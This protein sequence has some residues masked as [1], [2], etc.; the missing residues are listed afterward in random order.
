MKKYR[1]YGEY[2]SDGCFH[3]RTDRNKKSIRSECI[4]C[5]CDIKIKTRKER[6]KELKINGCSICG[7]DKCLSA[8]EFHHVNPDEKTFL[9]N[10]THMTKGYKTI[11]SELE[12]CILLCSNCHKE[13]HEGIIK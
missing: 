10:E 8:L 1:I 7:Y 11:L 13:I 4:R 9:L 3:P 5:Q 12:K 2:K 6:V